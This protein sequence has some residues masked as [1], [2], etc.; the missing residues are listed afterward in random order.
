VDDV[1]SNPQ[2][3]GIDGIA[4][5]YFKYDQ[6][7]YQTP[8]HIFSNLI[9]QLLSQI[10]DVYDAV[11]TLYNKKLVRQRTP[12]IEELYNILWSSGKVLFVF[13]GL[14]EASNE[15][16]GALVSLLAKL[17]ANSVCVLTSRPTISLQSISHK[18]QIKD[19]AVQASDLEVF[20]RAQLKEVVED[21]PEATIE[22]ITRNVIFHA[23][24][25]YVI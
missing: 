7:E 15:T 6:Q 18:T 24:G 25:K 20:I 1:K 9:A 11:E 13:D 5:I 16:E 3:Y 10:D 19:V 2:K 17:E 4:Y 23:D 14:D 21:I 22:E 8:R 12:R